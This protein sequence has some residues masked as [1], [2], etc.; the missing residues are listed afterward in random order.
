MKH[1]DIRF[2]FVMEILN[3]GDIVLKKIHTK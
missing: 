2:H 3:E 1:I